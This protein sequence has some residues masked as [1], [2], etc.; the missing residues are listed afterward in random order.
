MDEQQAHAWVDAMYS[1]TLS[2]SNM[3]CILDMYR[4]TVQMH[5]PPRPST[6]VHSRWHSSAQASRPTAPGVPALPA[7]VV[8]GRGGK[9]RRGEA[10]CK[11]GVARSVRLGPGL[12][13]ARKCVLAAQEPGRHPHPTCADR[14]PSPQRPHGFGPQ[15]RDDGHV[16]C[17]QRQ[18][19]AQWQGH[20][21]R[22]N[23][24]ARANRRGG[25]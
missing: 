12:H 7:A 3:Y 17:M 24:A 19:A 20:R 15:L 1:C 18:A 10:R 22:Q 16:P 11:Q 4:H 25:G 6:A 13:C 14:Q 23:G 8:R 9:A 5:Q 2:L 21:R